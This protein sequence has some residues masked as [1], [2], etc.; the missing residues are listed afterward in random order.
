ML[1]KPRRA[2]AIRDLPAIICELPNYDPHLL[3]G[4]SVFNEKLAKRAIKFIETELY[5]SKGAK[6]RTP[7]LLERWQKAI[8]A[9]LFGW[10]R[11]D[12]T[13][14]YREAFIFVG[15][16]NGK[17]PLAAAIITYL[18]FEDGEPGSEIYGAASEYKQASLVFS[19]VHGFIRQNPKLA[20]RCKVYQGQAKAVQLDSDYSTYRVASSDPGS[21][22][23][24]NSAAYVVDEVHA[25]RDSEL[26]D[27]LETSVGARRQPLGVLISTSDY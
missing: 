6:A 21:L 12:G 19:H 4:D 23:G 5:H 27:V 16:K 13:R 3:A 25:L 2:R 11:P 7:F 18:L 24:A 22:H 14:R 17:T 9:N 26:V 8:V 15:R 1:D 10:V 20:E